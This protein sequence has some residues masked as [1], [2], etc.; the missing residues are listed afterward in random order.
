M[1]NPSGSMS[2]GTSSSLNKLT[3]LGAG[4]AGGLA[5]S[6]TLAPIASLAGTAAGIY[7]SNK[8]REL[9][10]EIADRNYN[11]QVEN[12]NYQKELQ[13]SIF[14]REDNA[15]QRMSADLLSA[16][17]SKTLAAGNGANAGQAI[18]TTAPQ[19]DGTGITAV[20]AEMRQLITGLASQMQQMDLSERQMEVTERMADAEIEN[21]TGIR[22]LNENKFTWE[23]TVNDQ[24]QQ[25]WERAFKSANDTSSAQQALEQMKY[26]LTKNITDTSIK[27]QEQQINDYER[28][29]LFSDEAKKIREDMPIAMKQI[30]FQDSVANSWGNV[31]KSIL[32]QGTGALFGAGAN[33]LQA[34]G[35]PGGWA[36]G[37]GHNLNFGKK[38]ASGNG[39]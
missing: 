15:V 31:G 30:I 10:K 21:M 8:D 2:A 20:G 23:K 22:K 11:L 13:K 38:G 3:A 37:A 5:L 36:G 12:L 28:W 1:F 7:S 4:T 16:G 19:Y 17:L 32:Q 29:L 14:E 25:N 27:H 6:S 18:T 9:Q 33:I 34:W 39:K 35:S 26:E 24:D